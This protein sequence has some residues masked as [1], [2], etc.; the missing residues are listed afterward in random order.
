[1]WQEAGN[2]KIKQVPKNRT[3]LGTSEPILVGNKKPDRYVSSLSHL[4]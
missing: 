3:L 4:V 2:H 1:M